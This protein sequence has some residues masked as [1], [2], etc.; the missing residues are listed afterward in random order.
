MMP[1]SEAA[2]NKAV[3]QFFSNGGEVTVL[4]AFEAK[5]L[6]PRRDQ[7]VRICPARLNAPRGMSKAKLKELS[8]A[9]DSVIN[10]G[11]AQRVMAMASM[12]LSLIQIANRTG[13]S[14]GVIEALSKRLGFKVLRVAAV[15]SRPSKAV[16]DEL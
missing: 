1:I 14:R 6:P 16:M 5:P 12:G 13:I 15:T 11:K 9:V 10:E 8:D 7:S 4:P 2:L 3:N